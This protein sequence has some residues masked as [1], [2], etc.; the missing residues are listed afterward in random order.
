METLKFTLQTKEAFENLN[1]GVME[2]KK[3]VEKW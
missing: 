1:R 2:Q 3:L